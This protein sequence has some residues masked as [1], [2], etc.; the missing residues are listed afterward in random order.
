METYLQ[1][2]LVDIEARIRFLKGRARPGPGRSNATLFRTCRERLDV[3]AGIAKELR[4]SPKWLLP[5][6]ASARFRAFRGLVGD[7]DQLEYVAVQVL[8]R[9][10]DDDTSA[11]RFVEQIAT[12]IAYPLAPPVVACQAR[13]YYH[14]YPD[15]GL[16]LIPPAEGAFLLHLPDLYHELA[17]PLL[18]EFNDPKLHSVQKLFVQLWTDAQTYV[19]DELQREESRRLTPQAFSMYLTGWSRSWR[20]WIA[21]FLCDAF[22]A[23]SLGP[24]FAWAHLH[25]TAKRGSDPFAVPLGGVS[26][27]PADAARMDVVLALLRINGWGSD[28]DS[29]RLKLN[30][31]LSL[32]GYSA[33]P[34]YGRCFPSAF[35][36][37]IASLTNEALTQMGCPTAMRTSLAE[38]AGILNGAWTE[39]WRDP[40]EYATWQSVNAKAIGLSID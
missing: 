38:I 11:N 4:E 3:A 23:H 25:L 21:E 30:S 40:A 13:E 26:S 31:L 19:H 16:M 7:L 34:E 27:H 8:D 32:G 35:L 22:A 14:T 6:N 36:L 9:W 17:H 15:L 10:G 12:E 24:A 28:A 29:V 5:S 33:S 37:K 39:F 18:T 2:A 1:G 20:S